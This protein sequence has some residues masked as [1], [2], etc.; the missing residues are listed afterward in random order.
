MRAGPLSKAKVVSLLN[1]YFVPVYTSNEDYRG[2]GAAPSEERAE[3]RRIVREAQQAKLSTGTVH[4]FIL[5]PDGHAVDSL[6]VAAA[7]KVETLIDMLERNIKKFKTPEG[8]PLVKPVAQSAAPKGEPGSL[9]L[10]VTSRYLT[11]QGD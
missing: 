9:I 4:A 7:S 1:S 10:H 11:R 6:H 5:S 8:Q 2:D 3:H